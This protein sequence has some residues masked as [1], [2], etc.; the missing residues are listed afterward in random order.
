M[1]INPIWQASTQRAWKL[2][3]SYKLFDKNIM[4]TQK[5]CNIKIRGK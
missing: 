5:Q 3:L 2:S 1:Q 4:V